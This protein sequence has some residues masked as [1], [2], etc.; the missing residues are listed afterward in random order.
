[1]A[2]DHG[3]LPKANPIQLTPALHHQLAVWR[4]KAY[5]DDNLF[6]TLARRPAVLDLFL[7][8][9]RFVYTGVCTLDPKLLELCRLRLAARNQCVH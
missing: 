6:L 8:W 3:P 5:P 9:A 7:R 1:M 2:N 4:D